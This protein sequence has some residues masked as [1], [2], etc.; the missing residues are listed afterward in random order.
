MAIS[1]R[2]F[3][4]KYVKYFLD[5]TSTCQILWSQVTTLSPCQRPLGFTTWNAP[6]RLYSHYYCQNY[7]RT[8]F[9]MVVEFN[10]FIV[11]SSLIKSPPMMVK[12]FLIEQKLQN[13][14]W[15][16]HL[17]VYKSRASSDW[18]HFDSSLNTSLF[19]L[20]SYCS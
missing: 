18:W 8:V 4:I 2:K 20:S 19:L 16:I 9:E 10:C 14:T 1:M 5:H 7:C 12:K 17:Q 15:Y 3:P 11:N 6:W 13:K